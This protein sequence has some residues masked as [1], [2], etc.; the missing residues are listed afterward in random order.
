[1]NYAVNGYQYFN[2]DRKNEVKSGKMYSWNMAQQVC[3]QDWHLPTD[4]ELIDALQPYGNIS[5]SGTAEQYVSI[6]GSYKPRKT[7]VTYTKLIND[8]KIHIPVFPGFLVDDQRTMFW[9]SVSSNDKRAY[10]IYWRTKDHY[11]DYNSV[12][13]SDYPKDLFGF[14]R[15]VRDQPN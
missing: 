15:C 4:K 10:A 14:C 2:R 3:P 12:H 8:K 1:M 13:F 11:I 5:Y 9:T 6:F 7:E